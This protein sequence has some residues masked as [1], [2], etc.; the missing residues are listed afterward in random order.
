LV[1]GT[2]E[3]VVRGGTGV[4]EGFGGAGALAAGDGVVAAVVGAGVALTRS[5]TALAT[6]GPAVTPVTAVPTVIRLPMTAIPT[7]PLKKLTTE[8]MPI[9]SHS[10]HRPTLSDS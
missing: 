8:S 4:D 6:D 1:R 10:D 9:D 3:G 2:G 7:G 5:V